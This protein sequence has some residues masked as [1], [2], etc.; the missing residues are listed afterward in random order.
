MDL[1]EEHK[2]IV[3]ERIMDTVIKALDAGQITM[4]QYNEMA[5]YIPKKADEIKTHHELL[6]FLRELSEKWSIFTFV[7]TL[8][9]GQVKKIE[10]NRAIEKVE[11]LTQMGDINQALEEAKKA[12][13]I[14]T[15]YES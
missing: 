12:T 14:S 15:N 2:L 8:E 4:G 5:D 11:Q 6:V 3:E 7:L 10:E 9:N 1:S 13:D